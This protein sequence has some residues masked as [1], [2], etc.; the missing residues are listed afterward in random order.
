MSREYCEKKDVKDLKVPSSWTESQVSY[1][2]TSKGHDNVYI[3]VITAEHKID[4][5]ALLLLTENDLKE[6]IGI[7][8]IVY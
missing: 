2:L 5:K 4:G 1:Y 3:Q 6:V 8:V 7:K